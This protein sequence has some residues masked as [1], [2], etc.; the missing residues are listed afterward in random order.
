MNIY[1]YYFKCYFLYNLDLYV[2]PAKATHIQLSN[3][4]TAKTKTS[5]QEDILKYAI[6]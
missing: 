5:K 1:Q 6:N 2:G 3:T 4:K